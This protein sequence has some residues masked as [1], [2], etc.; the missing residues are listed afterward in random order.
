[1]S[2]L[3]AVSSAKH[4]LWVLPTTLL[5]V[6]LRPQGGFSDMA[7]CLPAN[8]WEWKTFR[9]LRLPL[10]SMVNRIGIPFA[11]S[12]NDLGTT[13]APSWKFLPTWLAL[14]ASVDD[15]SVSVYFK[16][17]KTTGAAAETRTPVN[18]PETF[19]HDSY[20]TSEDKRLCQNILDAMYRMLVETETY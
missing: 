9:D 10:A 14:T 5:A 11:A 4:P 19:E 20:H 12:L 6:G 1:M 3:D 2:I 16:P 8:F 18:L 7:F 15:M 17:V 13:C